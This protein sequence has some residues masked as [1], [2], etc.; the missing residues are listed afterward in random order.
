MYPSLGSLEADAE[1]A[2]SIKYCGV[3][4]CMGMGGS[5]TGQVVWQ[6][7]MPT[8]WTLWQPSRSLEH[9]LPIGGLDGWGGEWLALYPCFVQSLT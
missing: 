4:L 2:R 1:A 5:R 7:A 6:V 9:S 3:N 8:W